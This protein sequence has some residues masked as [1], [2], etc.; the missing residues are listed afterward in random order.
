MAAASVYTDFSGLAGLKLQAQAEPDKAISEVAGQFESLFVGMMLKAMR[1]AVPQ[2]GLF[3]SSQM[4]TYRDLFDKQL[5]LDMSRSG[6]IGLAELIEQQIAT[7]ATFAA[8]QN[9]ADSGA[10]GI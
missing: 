10:P 4:D 7:S 9:K 3:D 5:A 2:G 8:T 6:G 1:D